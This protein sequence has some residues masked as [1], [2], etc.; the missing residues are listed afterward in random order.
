MS[1]SA[2]PDRFE[3][4][5][6]DRRRLLAAPGIGRDI[7]EFEELPAACAQQRAVVTCRV[8]R[9]GGSFGINDETAIREQPNPG[10]R[11]RSRRSSGRAFSV[12]S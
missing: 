7:R 10:Q 6:R 12:A 11:R 5:W 9:Y 8:R 3:R 4:D 1:G 2:S